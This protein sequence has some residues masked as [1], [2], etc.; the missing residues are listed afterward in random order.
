VQV[1]GA[2]ELLDAGAAPEALAALAAKYPQ[3]RDDPPPG[4]L[5]RLAPRRVLCWSASAG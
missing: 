5:L 2:V 3:Y 4:P 1:L